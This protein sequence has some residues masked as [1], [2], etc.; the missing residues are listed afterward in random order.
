METESRNSEGGR[1]K[2]LCQ[3]EDYARSRITSPVRIVIIS[4]FL[5]CSSINVTSCK[6]ICFSECTFQKLRNVKKIYI[7]TH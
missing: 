5:K 1:L 6:F 2:H 4:L 7:S 3:E